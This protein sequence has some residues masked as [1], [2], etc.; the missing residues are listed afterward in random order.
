[1]AITRIP[2]S[3]SENVAANDETW[4][5][6]TPP[7]GADLF[8]EEFRGEAQSNLNTS[9]RLVWKVDH[10]SEPEEQMWAINGSSQMGFVESIEGEA[11]GTRELGIVLTNDSG[12]SAILSG[13]AVIKVVTP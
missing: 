3:I 13:E 1:M 12:Q 9:I 5:S 8:I 11:D 7:A 2:I 6:Y 4:E 10:P